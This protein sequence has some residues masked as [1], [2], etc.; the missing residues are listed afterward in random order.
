MSKLKMVEIV[1]V[2]WPLKEVPYAW[3]GEAELTGTIRW[4][5]SYV[6]V[7]AAGHVFGAG[8][9]AGVGVGAGAGV[10]VGQLEWQPSAVSS[11]LTQPDCPW[12][13]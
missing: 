4:G 5:N 6:P 10:D 12:P 7:R 3:L 11:M 1:E 9:G 13:D 8:A 2:T